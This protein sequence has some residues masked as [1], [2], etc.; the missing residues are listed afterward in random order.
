MWCTGVKGCYVFCEF[1]IFHNSLDNCTMTRPH[2]GGV[3]CYHNKNNTGVNMPKGIGY[4]K[5]MKKKKSLSK[6]KKK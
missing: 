5:G 3:L 6:K 2:F 1:H 4:P